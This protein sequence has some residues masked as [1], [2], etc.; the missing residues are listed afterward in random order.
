MSCKIVYDNQ[1]NFKKALDP[2]GKESK[3][4]KQILK[5]PHVKSIKDAVDLYGNIYSK[6]MYSIL[7]LKGVQNLDDVNNKTID[8]K[9]KR[10]YPIFTKNQ[11]F[12]GKNQ[13]AKKAFENY[14]GIILPMS[15]NF[16]D[17]DKLFGNN[18]IDDILDKL[19]YN[20]IEEDYGVSLDDINN[21]IN[22]YSSKYDTLISLMDEKNFRVRNFQVALQMEAEGK[23][24]IEI[25][26]A[27]LWERHLG[28]NKWRYEVNDGELLINDFELNKQY[29]ISDIFKSDVTKAYPDIKFIITEND[30]R[31]EAGSY[32]SDTNTIKIN[33]LFSEFSVQQASN[34]GRISFGDMH[35]LRQ[36]I[37]HELSHASQFF[38]GFGRGGNPRFL[39]FR[40]QNL[41][42][43][44]EGEPKEVSIRKAE[45]FINST[46]NQSERIL[47]NFFIDYLKTDS[48]IEKL[49]IL[50][51]AYRSISG[52]VEARVVE[53]RSLMLFEDFRDSL[54]SRDYE[55]SAEDQIYISDISS[56]PQ[57]SFKSD[58][59][60]QFST[61]KEA[62]LDSNGG[63]IDIQFDQ[64]VVGVVSSKQDLTTE[65]GT[66]NYLV[67]NNLLAEDK[68]IE[69][70]KVYL[71]AEGFDPIKQILNEENMKQF[72]PL[73]KFHRDGRIEILERVE[74]SPLRN[75]FT[76]S[77]TSLD[78]GKVDE[79][80]LKSRL[81]EFLQDVGVSVTTIDNYLERFNIRNGYEASAEAIADIGRQV[82][83]F[84][85]GEIDVDKLTEETAHFI[86]ES[87]DATEVDNLT[88]N[89]HKTETFKQFYQIYYD[90]YKRE[91]PQMTEEELD[92]LVRR[93]ILAKEL[94]NNLIDKFNPQ[95]KEPNILRKLLDLFLNF[96]NTIT[97]NDN[98]QKRLD[99]LTDKVNEL[100]INKDA[101]AY[102]EL[103]KSKKFRMYSL[104]SDNALKALVDQERVLIRAGEGSSKTAKELEARIGEELKR[105][106]VEQVASLARRQV[107]YVASAVKDANKKKKPLSVE[108]QLTLNNLL[109]SIRPAL[110]GLI[111]SISKE[112]EY[113]R[114][115]ETMK[116]TMDDISTISAEYQTAE[117]DI[118]DRLVKRIAR[119]NPSFTEDQIKAELKAVERDTSYL[120]SYFGQISHAADPILN[121][122]SVV[123]SDIYNEARINGNT[124]INQMLDEI[125]GSGLKP[126]DFEKIVGE[127]G[128]IISKWNHEEYA[129]FERY[130]YAKAY[131]DNLDAIIASAE[132]GSLEKEVHLEFKNLSKEE[133]IAKFESLPLIKDERISAKVNKEASD[134]IN[135]GTETTLS[136]EEINK[137]LAQNANLHPA[138]L[139]TMRKFMEA[140]GLLKRN[141][142]KS[143]SGIPI[144]TTQNKYDMQF[145]NL[146]RRRAMSFY[147]EEA[148][149]TLK[150]GLVIENIVR[151][152]D[153]FFSKTE[154]AYI[155]LDRANASDEA[156]VAFE[157]S[158]MQAE[159]D[160]SGRPSGLTDALLND[161]KAMEKD[162]ENFAREDI[163]DF[164]AL[165]TTFGFADDYFN[166]VSVD[167]FEAVKD[168]EDIQPALIEYKYSLKQRKAIL[169]KYRDPNDATNIL[170]YNIT[171]LDREE[172]KIL[173]D[174][175]EKSFK[176]V[177]TKA[178]K[179]NLE[180]NFQSREEKAPNESYF[181]ALKDNNLEDIDSQLAFTLKHMTDDARRAV[182][183][184]ALA[185]DS[186]NITGRHA[187]IQARFGN[188]KEGVLKYAQSKM[189]PYYTSV[190]P[191]A[192]KE[193]YDAV[194]NS[195]IS[196]SEALEKMDKDSDVKITVAYDYADVKNDDA[197][198]KNKDA[199]W[200][201]KT[202][203]P[204]LRKPAPT[205]LGRTFDFKN[206]EWSK[207]ANDPK[208]LKAQE[209]AVNRNVKNLEGYGADGY[210]NPYLIPQV[211]RTLYGKIKGSLN[212]ESF[213]EFKERILTEREDEQV[214][215]ESRELHQAG[216]RVIPKRYLRKLDKG[217]ATTDLVYSM[218]MMTKEVELYKAR[219]KYYGEVT[220]LEQNL[221]DRKF[222]GGKKVE[223]T[224]TYEMFQ[225][226]KDNFMFGIQ[227]NVQMRANVPVL[228]EIDIT[229]MFK[230][231]HKFISTLSL[232][233]NAVIPIT[234]MFTAMSTF[235]SEPFV[236][237]YTDRNSYTR[238]LKEATKLSGESAGEVGKINQKSKLSVLGTRFGI[239][240]V[241]NRLENATSSKIEKNL[242]TNL[243]MGGHALGNFL[244]LNHAMLTGIMSHRVHDRK[245]LTRREFAGSDAEWNELK[246]LYDY[247]DVE[248]N[249]V[250]YK[251][252]FFQDTDY[253]KEDWASSERAIIARVG[254]IIE[255]IDGQIKPEDKTFAQRNFLLKFTQTHKSWLAI[256][257]ANAFKRRH[258]N[259]LTGQ[260][261][262]GKYSGTL[263][264]L[265][266]YFKDANIKD[267]KS[268]KE[269]FDKAPIE[270]KVALRRVLIDFGN[271]AAVTLLWALFSGAADD[272]E[273]NAVLQFANYM[274]LRVKNETVS[275]QLG[276]VGEF[277]G[278]MESPIVGLSRIKTIATI[279]NAFSGEEITRGR[280][281]GLT[282]AERYFIQA[283]P[284]VKPAY[285][286]WDAENI[287]SQA[288][289]Y[290]FFNRKND[291]FNV[292]A[293]LISQVEGDEEE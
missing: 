207:I 93:E 128:Y 285:D 251:D 193:Y 208:L 228:G 259:Y 68:I 177:M 152:P 130:A 2:Q 187:E 248:G 256:G 32:S 205:V 245:L 49:K 181:G 250:K 202:R 91:N 142:K 265:R 289:A 148:I 179:K 222:V 86:I 157:M 286:L 55:M 197:L 96:F 145:L 50:D 140:R 117:N 97:L 242:I 20:L 194:R 89:I 126:Q 263:A 172:I 269:V 141:M 209:I 168:D 116:K 276:I 270:E 60:N 107:N 258:N 267:F 169:S 260:G 257:S 131:L 244:P 5:I 231:L 45:D 268:F 122:L 12:D 124:E 149:S 266:R 47:V 166:N 99:E 22:R 82:I 213:K 237:Q 4:F 180:I 80:G 21:L 115:V 1:G 178:K 51:K 230:I 195:D 232:G 78:T 171:E 30:E 71:K 7:G 36:T 34:T 95:G 184:Y 33:S 29:N 28:D 114:L 74:P 25:K 191:K 291:M 224:R 162:T 173:T 249:E 254:K 100:L 11:L 292:W 201:S 61:F 41:A 125:Q 211:E 77:N 18:N 198:N 16:Y 271:L 40:A 175:I 233:F 186:G 196:I 19:P 137:R 215:G 54:M 204:S 15:A 108:E 138:T 17:L 143:P 63:D 151:F 223:M 161:I 156:I 102:F 264:H 81:L 121:M 192:L 48:A 87:W 274:A 59:G 62:L 163:A 73:S 236:K 206:K 216:I 158:K 188:S 214:F 123:A 182:Q 10:K 119:N 219:V 220:A 275:S 120:Y 174:R 281:K 65:G 241:I 64:E 112:A 109:F 153:N 3:L 105:S 261:E 9:L 144:L 183:G 287:R 253:T 88:R 57:L 127:D 218:A 243:A 147:K 212:K 290:E 8:D 56:E 255:R 83:A 190:A 167:A 106:T 26:R 84:K 129:E 38:E 239:F 134:I 31:R 118:L 217:E 262:Q 43:F 280:Y 58:K 66:I 150:D 246:T 39:L 278:S 200:K 210:I 176:E 85:N 90:A 282:E 24:P 46:T 288:Q 79:S 136:D 227:E 35:Q 283:V 37:I 293:Y 42:G 103:T 154:D 67:A 27:T 221:Q 240:D 199:D 203:E 13:Q 229:R 76:A 133:F 44:N 146:E 159:S 14:S 170:A 155:Q 104:P 113:K 6:R 252:E 110:D 235:A 53:K 189:L 101:R 164:V 273:D 92:N 132:D 279:P 135:T 238:G 70:D 185:V 52:E 272:D 72:L 277:Y 160:F 69:N 98:Y 284:G 234:S 111:N 139:A 225:S 226:A 94:A 23:S 247:M 165:N 75:V